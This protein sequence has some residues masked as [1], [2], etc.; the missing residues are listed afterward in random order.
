MKNAVCDK[1]D[2]SI[3]EINCECQHTT[4][5]LSYFNN[6]TEVES[7]RFILGASAPTDTKEE[8]Q[9]SKSP[10]H[11]LIEKNPKNPSVTVP[12]LQVQLHPYFA[13]S[14]FWDEWKN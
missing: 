13:I 3:V 6:E 9:N 5:H 1:Y 7:P 14:S 11:S 8:K 2:K 12:R 4:D 10:W